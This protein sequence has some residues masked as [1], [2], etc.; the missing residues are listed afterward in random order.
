MLLNGK[1]ARRVIQLL[2]DVFADA[3]KLAPADTL[4]VLWLVTN[5]GTWE[6]RRQRR[7]L[8]LLAGFVRRW[9]GTK[10]VQFCLDSLKVGVEQV[11]QQAALRWADLLA[12]LGELVALEDGNLVR[13]LLDDRLVTMDFSA[14]GV[15]LRQQLRSECA[16]LFGCHLVEIGRGS[17]AVD[18][19]KAAH[20]PQLKGEAK[21]M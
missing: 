12:A 10:R 7:A 21:S 4:G 18:F 14:H 5:D 3:L 17:H 8:G 16:Q 11:I 9:G 1:H 20:L 6:L 15:D 19:T 13:E 2:A